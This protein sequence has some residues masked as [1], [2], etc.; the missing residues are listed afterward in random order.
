MEAD[1]A[2]NPDGSPARDLMVPL[3]AFGVTTAVIAVP[4]WAAGYESI[5]DDGIFGSWRI[6]AVVLLLGTFLAGSVSEMPLVVVPPLMLLCVPIAVIGRVL[7]D[8]A[9]QPGSHDLWPLEVVLSAVLGAPAVLVGIL[10]AWGVR[11]L[12][13]RT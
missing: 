13:P 2:A 1:V 6:V 4:Y 11:R 7:I 5:R 3:V 9:S 8:T 10:L 12:S